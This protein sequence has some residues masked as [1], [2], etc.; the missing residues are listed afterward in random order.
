MC[1]RRPL[2]N[3]PLLTLPITTM[4]QFP[5]YWLLA[6]QYPKFISSPLSLFPVPGSPTDP[7]TVQILLPECLLAVT[8]PTFLMLKD[9][10]RLEK[11]R[12]SGGDQCYVVCA[13]PGEVGQGTGLRSKWRDWVSWGNGSGGTFLLLDSIS[14]ISYL[15]AAWS[16]PS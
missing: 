6:T 15:K 12:G 9:S 10:G 13:G 3:A 5:C 16:A 1:T 2:I 14:L 4:V 8:V 11:P 7:C